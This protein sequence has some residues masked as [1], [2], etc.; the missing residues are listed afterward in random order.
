MILAAFLFWCIKFKM[1]SLI[2]LFEIW[3]ILIRQSYCL[4][5]MEM[6]NYFTNIL[7]CWKFVGYIG[8]LYID[9]CI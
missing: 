3:Q 7:I 1:R 2:V 4:K 6:S 5:R 8:L 9:G